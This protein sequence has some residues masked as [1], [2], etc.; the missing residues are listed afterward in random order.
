MDSDFLIKHFYLGNIPFELGFDSRFRD[1]VDL[2]FLDWSYAP[3]ES[4]NST[5]GLD[6]ISKSDLHPVKI[7]LTVLESQAR[8]P[9][10]KLVYAGDPHDVERGYQSLQVFQVGAQTILSF[11][12]LGI[13]YHPGHLI[14]TC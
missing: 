1:V 5:R 9:Q 3:L 2:F 13:S 11:S 8:H 4:G 6:P 14:E 12:N 7:K 10:D